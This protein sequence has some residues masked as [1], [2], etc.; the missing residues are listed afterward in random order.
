MSKQSRTW[1]I[2][3]A[4]AGCGLAVLAAI[5]VIG[6]GALFVRD[7]MSG[8]EGAL[9]SRKAIDERFG[10]VA[11]FVPWPDGAVPAARM[12]AFLAVR[13]ALTPERERLAELFEALPMDPEQAQEL[14]RQ[15]FPEK[16][17]SVFKITR[18]AF[19][20][21]GEMGDFFE[22]RNRAL[23]D[24]GIGMGEYTYIYALAFHSWLGQPLDEGPADMQM[25]VASTRVRRNLRSMLQNQLAALDEDPGVDPIWRETLAAEIEVLESSPRRL[26]WEDG[27]PAALAASLEPYRE[28]LAASYNP[29]TNPFELARNRRRGRWSIQAE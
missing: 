4:A 13:E 3:C 28:R 1:L 24:Q 23:L 17:R 18:T 26:P 5:V 21:G 19:G 29:T 15:P 22:L 11:E 2:G 25:P 9:E 8:F 12:E 14:D 6:G 16:M 10:A 27:L 7:T 20:L